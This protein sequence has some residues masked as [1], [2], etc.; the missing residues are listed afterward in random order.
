MRKAGRRVPELVRM[1]FGRGRGAV[2]NYFRTWLLG[3]MDVLAVRDVG[4]DRVLARRGWGS[5]TVLEYA[6]VRSAVACAAVSCIGVCSSHFGGR[7]PRSLFELSC[8]VLSDQIALASDRVPPSRKH[9][10]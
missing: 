5:S 1:G 6:A 2:T 3:N 10:L 8:R 4:D 9:F 7:V